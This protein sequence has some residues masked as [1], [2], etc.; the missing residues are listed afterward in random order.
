MNPAPNGQPARHPI[1]QPPLR[2]PPGSAPFSNPAAAPSQPPRPFLPP[3]G[4]ANPNFAQLAGLANPNG[5]NN[6]IP[7]P[8]M[9]R[10]ASSGMSGGGGGRPQGGG[11]PSFS[12]GQGLRPPGM[13]PSQPQGPKKTSVSDKPRSKWEG[14]VR[15][16]IQSR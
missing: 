8:S 1:N 7:G 9:Q 10:P 13:G 2:P 11:R 15:G 6:A 3:P 12:G 5:P 16:L 4:S 14:A